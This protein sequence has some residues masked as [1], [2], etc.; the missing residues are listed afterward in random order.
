[1]VSGRGRAGAGVSGCAGGA[2]AGISG[3]GRVGFGP[4]GGVL[5]SGVGSGCGRLSLV[6]GLAGDWVVCAGKSG[7]TGRTVGGEGAMGA[8]APGP[9][10]AG[11][12]VGV[13]GRFA[14]PAGASAWMSVLTVFWM[15][16]RRSGLATAAAA[17]APS[18]RDRAAAAMARRVCRLVRCASRLDMV[19]DSCAAVVSVFA[20]V[21]RAASSPRGVGCGPRARARIDSRS[22]LSS[23]ASPGSLM[24]A[25]VNR[26]SMTV[27]SWL[28]S[29]LRESLVVMMCVPFRFLPGFLQVGQCPALE[30][31]DSPWGFVH[32]PGGGFNG[33][34]GDHAQGEDFTVIPRQ[35]FQ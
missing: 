19:S 35:A 3:S 11:L 9:A 27:S 17:P 25:S 15:V 6:S 31:F 34:F 8:V 28:A 4:S 7:F 26:F 22:G 10:E 1:M 29:G 14:F 13:P 32:D 20:P 12:G 23:P 18:E 30:L 2:G 24:P 33:Q 5:N 21:S 16:S